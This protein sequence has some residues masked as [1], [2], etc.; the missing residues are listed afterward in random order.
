ME[1]IE[2]A[3]RGLECCAEAKCEVCPYEDECFA[4][5]ISICSPMAKDMLEVVKATQK[6]EVELRL[7]CAPDIEGNTEHDGHGSWWYVCGACRQ[8]I[9]KGDR[10]CRHC[11][12][13]VIW[14]ED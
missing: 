2:K 4:E 5:E 14:S 8:P 11:G 7:P 6:G 1:S 9:D 13:G 10:Y 3:I 12:N